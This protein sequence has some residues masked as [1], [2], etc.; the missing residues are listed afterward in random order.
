V[1]NREGF[2]IR[3][4][5]GICPCQDPGYGQDSYNTQIQYAR[6]PGQDPGPE[7]WPGSCRSP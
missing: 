6:D 4:V 5:P 7:I 1:C 2:Y 3:G